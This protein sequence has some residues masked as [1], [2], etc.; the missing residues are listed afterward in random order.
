MASELTIIGAG[1]A[2]SEAA[3]QAAEAGVSVRLH[4]MRP[5]RNTE[6]HSSAD[7]AELVCS[8]SLGSDVTDRP[9]GLLKAEAREL[10]SL[11]LACADAT[12][13]PAG[14]ALAVDRDAFAGE[15]TR[16]LTAHPRITIDR[17]E[18]TGIPDGPT[19]IAS[20]PLTSQSLAEELARLSGTEHLFFFDAISPIV[21]A[22][23]IDMSRAFRQSRWD[24]EASGGGDYINCPLER[25]EYEAFVDALLS[26]ERIPLH[27]F[28]QAIEGGV[29]AGVH[30]FFEGCLP[31][32]I[33]AARG[34]DALA[35]GPLRPVGLTDPRTGQRPYACVQL[36]QDDLAGTLYNL[37]GFQTNLKFAE[38]AR[39]FGLIP[40]L[41]DADWTRFGQMHRNTFLA[42]PRLLR[43]TLQFR[44]RDDLF[45]AGQ[46]T[47]IEGY[48]GNIASGLLAGVNAA[49]QLQGAEPLVLPTDTMLGA[50]CHYISHAD[51]EHFQP[52]KANMGLLP[53][54]PPP[55]G[56]RKKWSKR[57]RA[58]RHA[59][60]ALESL[61]TYCGNAQTGAV[62]G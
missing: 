18:V 61:A 3:W 28:E 21:S 40:G 34:R 22:D 47:G 33:I 8:N 62:A 59:E 60:R 35:Y 17:G 4:E 52:M 49:R 6:A 24:R 56:R 5:A 53:A 10:G 2:G 29:K 39:V 12:A 58:A 30:R 19:I 25:D 54:L 38:Q 48:A 31:I 50:L 55:P 46:L 32:E 45:C 27:S 9:S 36:R 43:S 51:V 1:L 42:A 20:G 11:L 23:S 57:E 26:A 44:A 14:S 7:C 41:A 37:V 15:V 16:R 13:V